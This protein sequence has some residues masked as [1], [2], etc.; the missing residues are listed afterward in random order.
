MGAVFIVTATPTWPGQTVRASVAN[1]GSQLGTPS[2]LGAWSSADG[3]FIVFTSGV[4]DEPTLTLPSVFVR[5]RQTGQTTLVSKATGSDVSIGG[6]LPSITPDG[7]Y[8][9]FLSLAS[10]LPG[11]DPSGSIDIYLHDRTTGQTERVSVASNGTAG[12]GESGLA[13]ISA[14]GRYVAFSST[15]TNL[16]A[17]DTDDQ[18]D[19]Y[20]R[21]RLAGTTTLLSVS[22]A[23]VKGN[24]G[25]WLPTLS[26]DGR[27][28]SFNSE[29]TNLVPID[30]LGRIDLFVRDLWAGQTARVSVGTGGTQA[31]Q[32]SQGT[33]QRRRPVRAL[34]HRRL[35]PGHRRHQRSW[36]HLCARSADR[37][38]HARQRVERGRSGQWRQ[39]RSEPQRRWTICPVSVVGDQPGARGYQRPGGR[40]RP[41]PSDRPDRARQR[42]VGWYAGQRRQYWHD[43]DGCCSFPSISADGRSVVVV[44]LASNLVPGRHQRRRRRLRSRPCLGRSDDGGCSRHQAAPGPSTCRST[45]PAPRGRRRRR[46]RGSRSTRQPA[47]RRT[48]PS[49]SRPRRMP[50]LPPGPARSSWR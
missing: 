3:R 12:N 7:R 17:G 5:D 4:F 37:S 18:E 33:D 24:A 47:D 23:G 22:T 8:V 46:P 48:A 44:T 13:S 45:I 39:R 36:R 16:A 14:D 10:A 43:D 26:A 20:V 40:V 9:I 50:A 38:D 11:G 21:D 15:A 19:V 41:R 1:D 29:A 2:N 28:V 32:G 30:N 35:Q 34:R 25:S 31:N 42:R 6:A 27:F 49:R